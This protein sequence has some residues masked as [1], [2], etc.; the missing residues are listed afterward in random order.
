[1]HREMGGRA[2][3]APSPTLRQGG[4]TVFPSGGLRRGI[5]PWRVRSKGP[6]LGASVVQSPPERLQQDSCGG[7]HQPPAQTCQTYTSAV[8]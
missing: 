8:Q 7:L 6:S 1:M 5:D 2:V 3:G 4:G